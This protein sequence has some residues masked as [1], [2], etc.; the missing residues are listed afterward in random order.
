GVI[1]TTSLG[2]IVVGQPAF[3]RENGIFDLKALE[4]QAQP[5]Q[6]EGQTVIFVAI[7]DRPAGIIA[8]ADPIKPSTPTAVQEL[9][10]MGLKVV[11]LTGDNE[12]AAR[13][14]AKK[15]GIDQVEA[16]V[17]TKDK[18]ERSTRQRE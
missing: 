13:A 12:R 10:R 5:L 14:V 9:Q 15:R 6:E 2:K 17:A 8:V 3:L 4:E 1:A 18:H 7:N 16:G 11:M